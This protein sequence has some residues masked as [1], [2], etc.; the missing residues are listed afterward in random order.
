MGQK[1]RRAGKAVSVSDSGKRER[2]KRGSA[3]NRV[4]GYRHS[5]NT[6]EDRI[7]VSILKVRRKSGNGYFTTVAPFR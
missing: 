3:M 6:R 4:R 5:Y 7:A 1:A 2:K